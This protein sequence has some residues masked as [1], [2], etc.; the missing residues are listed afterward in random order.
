MKFLIGLPLIV[1]FCGVIWAVIRR[2]Q[3]SRQRAPVTEMVQSYRCYHHGM[4]SRP[5]RKPIEGQQKNQER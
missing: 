3:E 1:L 4:P 5:A 2:I